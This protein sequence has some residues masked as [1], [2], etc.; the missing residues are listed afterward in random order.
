LFNISKDITVEEIKQVV[1]SC[2]VYGKLAASDEV[3]EAL[4]G[5]EET[6]G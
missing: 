1:L 5:M 4:R 3:K 2:K 6:G